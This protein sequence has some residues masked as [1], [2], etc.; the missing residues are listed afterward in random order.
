MIQYQFV[1]SN[2]LSSK[3][4]RDFIFVRCRINRFIENQNK[5]DHVLKLFKTS[6]SRS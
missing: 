6:K 2:I 4:Y 3:D 5:K 1:S